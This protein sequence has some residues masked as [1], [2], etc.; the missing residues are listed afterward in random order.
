MFNTFSKFLLLAAYHLATNPI[1]YIT[2]LVLSQDN[3]FVSELTNLLNYINQAN[4]NHCSLQT[5]YQDLALELD[6]LRLINSN[7]QA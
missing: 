4:N 2:T 5:L 3:V 7:L 6:S 1:A